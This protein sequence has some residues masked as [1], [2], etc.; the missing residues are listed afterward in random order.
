MAIE[1]TG[2]VAGMLK[3][4]GGGSDV[5]ITQLLSEGVAIAIV[6]VDDNNITLYAP[7][8]GGSDVEVTPALLSG[9]KIAD[10]KVDN[11][12]IALYAPAP[13]SV[14]VSQVLSEGTKIA[15]IGVNGVST[16]IYAPSGG[17]GGDEYSQTPHKVGKYVENNVEYDVWEVMLVYGAQYYGEEEH[18]LSYLNIYKLLDVRGSI[19]MNSDGGNYRYYSPF[20]FSNSLFDNYRWDDTNKILITLQASDMYGKVDSRMITIRY[21]V[22]DKLSK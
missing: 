4:L 12:T 5:E 1:L 2:N 22:N 15:T 10:I 17:G 3:L 19:K 18:N 16:D 20:Y 11:D 6:K 9:T 21:L 7:E 8:G 14:N 13:T